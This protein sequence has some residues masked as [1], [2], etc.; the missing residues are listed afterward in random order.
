MVSCRNNHIPFPKIKTTSKVALLSFFIFSLFWIPA[1]AVCQE[2]QSGYNLIGTIQ[3][4]D[5]TGAVIAVSKSEQT[6]FRKFDKLPD[7]SQIIEVLPESIVLKRADGTKYE[8]YTL[9]ETKTVASAQPPTPANTYT[10]SV[11]PPNPDPLNVTPSER[12]SSKSVGKR[13]PL[14]GRRA[15]E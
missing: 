7:G 8:I 4:G 1:E 15:E 6:F 9:H 2:A 11:P 14:N 3:S 12:F 13:R 5:L 10:S